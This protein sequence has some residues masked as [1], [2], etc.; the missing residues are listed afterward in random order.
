MTDTLGRGWLTVISLPDQC[1]P[2]INELLALAQGVGFEELYV[3]KA[4]SA[5]N[6]WEIAT[7]LGQKG[8]KVPVL[9]GKRVE[10]VGQYGIEPMVRI[11]HK[12]ISRKAPILRRSLQEVRY[13]PSSLNDNDDGV[14]KKKYLKVETVATLEF[15]C[16][17]GLRKGY[18]SPAADSWVDFQII[19]DLVDKLKLKQAALENS[20][21]ANDIRAGLRHFLLSCS[22][23]TL[24]GGYATYYIPEQLG[25][26]DRLMSM[27]NYVRGMAQLS[28]GQQPLA[29]VFA[30]S[31]ADPQALHDVTQASCDDVATRLM[32]LQRQAVALAK[33]ADKD[34]EG[35]RYEKQATRLLKELLEIK[36]LVGLL[37]TSLQDDLEI[38]ET[39]YQPCLDAVVSI[40]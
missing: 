15:D 25:M 16:Q 33:S 8:L 21:T 40:Q 14:G 1:H 11:E 28:P 26:Y 24:V 37:K 36:S 13:V 29:Y 31:A 17:T 23:V 4:K 39:L 22:R 10:I 30:V 20:C 5:R 19:Q 2:P 32:A 3:P 9:Y 18:F 7:N 6:A 38:L 27:R 35:A 34:K 12:N